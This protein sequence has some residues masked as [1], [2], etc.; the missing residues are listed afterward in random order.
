MT[1][2][3]FRLVAMASLAVLARAAAAQEWSPRLERRV[4]EALDPWQA[5]AFAAGAKASEIVLADGRTLEELLVE[6]AAE[7]NVPL[8]YMP[9]DACQLVR[10]AGSPAGPLQPGEARPFRARGNLRA[11]GGA[12]GGCGLPAA[13]RALAIVTRAVTRGKGSL[14]LGPAGQPL[15][16]LPAL[17]Y[18]TAASLTAP[19]LVELC[20]GETCA[21]DFQARA[22]GAAAHLV[23]SVVGYFAPVT[24][25]GPKGDSGPPGPKG[26]PGPAGPKGDPGVSGPPGPP[27]AP[28]APG[29]AG[30]QGPAGPEGPPGDPASGSCPLDYVIRGFQPN[31]TP[32][33]VAAA[34]LLSTVD[35]EGTV[36]DFSSIALGADGLPVIAYLDETNG[37]LKVAK[38]NDAACAGG[39]ETLTT[40][41]DGGTGRYTAIV[42]GA[43]GL[44]LISY[45]DFTNGS[46]RVAKCNDAACAGGDETLSTVDSGGVG[47]HTSIALG[48]D[49]L[50]VISYFDFNVTNFDLKVAKCNDAAC[51]GSDETL[52]TVDGVGGEDNSIALG[53]DGLPVISYK[54]VGDLKVAKCNDVACAGGD[55]NLSIVNGA[56]GADYISMVVGADGLPVISFRLLADNIAV[57]RCND[58]AC[59]GGNET[60]SKVDF[61]QPSAF[62]FTSIAMGADGLP[63][64][65]YHQE[66]GFLDLKV[67]KCNDAACAGGNET[68]STVDSRGTAGRYPSIAVG[69]DGLPVISYQDA[70]LGDLKVAKCANQ[71]CS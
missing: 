48:A 19:A 65:S 44:P 29:P 31:G 46:L 61:G 52:S 24:G 2:K 10:T 38:C 50:P 18:A 58:P 36:G 40:V 70:T 4:L 6:A 32:L 14:L 26:D 57:V 16:G 9:V 15:T 54:S 56:S 34:T 30:S 7:V 51:A 59:A 20:Q 23:V 33:C 43:D 28:G 66:G 35:S 64:I 39:D 67:A 55:E 12:A 41:D 3:R 47:T 11:Q 60:L 8:A 27:G 17:E 45:H 22:N 25:A 1:G 62:R 37:A 68:V 71:R 49:G 21:A 69:A 53:A 42:L 63:V 13:A 5:E